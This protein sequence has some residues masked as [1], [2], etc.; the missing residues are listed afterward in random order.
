MVGETGL[1]IRRCDFWN[2]TASFGAGLQ[3]GNIEPGRDRSYLPRQS[4]SVVDCWFSS[5]AAHFAGSGAHLMGP[6]MYVH[7]CLL[8]GNLMPIDGGSALY[9]E[10][11]YSGSPRV[12]GTNIWGNDGDEQ[13]VGEWIDEGANCIRN[14]SLPWVLC[15][16]EFDVDGNGFIDWHDWYLVLDEMERS[17]SDRTWS[18]CP[19][20]CHEDVNSDGRVDHLDLTLISDYIFAAPSEPVHRSGSG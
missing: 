10:Y 3:A 20:R 19:G 8:E 15:A 16:N 17:I 9:F 12:Q 1:S 2:N 4:C 18:G 14:H 11:A 5:N 13:I 6:D 7:G